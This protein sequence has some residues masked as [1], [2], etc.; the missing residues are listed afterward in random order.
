MISYVVKGMTIKEILEEDIKKY[1]KKLL[2]KYKKKY[3]NVPYKFG[4]HNYIF[5]KKNR[6]YH[7]Y[8]DAPSIVALI[9][10]GD[11]RVTKEW[12]RKGK[13]HREND[14]PAIIWRDRT[15]E[16]YRKGKLHRENDK[17]AVI[18]PNGRKEYWYNGKQYFPLRS[19]KQKK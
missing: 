2:K 7:S 11:R 18:Y 9:D 4:K 8:N 12:H 17:P 16:W 1:V 6:K 3:P 14:K 13:L 15:K 10:Y 5:S 19:K